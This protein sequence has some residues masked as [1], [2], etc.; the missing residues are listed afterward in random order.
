MGIRSVD[1]AHAIAQF[2]HKFPGNF[3]GE[4]FWSKILL[5]GWK[6]GK[7]RKDHYAIMFTSLDFHAGI[8]D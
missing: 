7:G 1:L 2:S 5:P 6:I 8:F 3:R 4:N